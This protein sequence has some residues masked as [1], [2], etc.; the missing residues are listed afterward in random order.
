MLEVGL[1]V[2]KTFCSR[3]ILLFEN[4][5]LDTRTERLML[6][7]KQNRNVKSRVLR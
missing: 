7:V 4:S 3:Y 1:I 6:D 5:K 2:F